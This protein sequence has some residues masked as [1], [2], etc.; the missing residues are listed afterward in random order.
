[1]VA[2]IS[3]KFLLDD[4]MGSTNEVDVLP[5]AHQYADPNS[6]LGNWY[7]NQSPSYRLLFE[8]LN[9]ELVLVSRTLGCSWRSTW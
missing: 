5:S 4:N 6:I 1:M 9:G 3:L 7:L 2:F 8:T